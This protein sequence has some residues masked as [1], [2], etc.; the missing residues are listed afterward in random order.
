ME[1]LAQFPHA[2]LTRRAVNG[3]LLFPDGL[4]ELPSLG[5]CRRLVGP[6]RFF[7]PRQSVPSRS[8]N[9]RNGGRT[10]MRDGRDFIRSG[11]YLCG[12]DVGHDAC[13]IGGVA[14]SDGTPSHEII[15]KTILGL[16]NLEHRGGLCGDTGDG[17]GLICQIPQAFFREAAR[18]CRLAG[19]ADVRPADRLA[20][21]VVFIAET[22]DGRCGQVRALIRQTLS[23]RPFHW[24]GWRPVPTRDDVLPALAR[25]TKPHIEHLLLRIEADPAAAERQLY[26]ARLELR[27]HFRTA[28]LDVSIPTLSSRV[29]GYKGLLTGP[30][31]A[32]FYPDLADP[33]F[34]TGL[35]LFHRRYSTNTFPNWAL[36]QPFRLLCHNGEINTIRTTRNAVRAYA[37]GRVPPPPGRDLLTP[38]VS[39]SASLDE[40]IEHLV[41]AR[42]WSLLRALRLS[43]PPVWDSE[44]DA[45]GSE[46]VDLFMYARRAFGGLAAWDGPA[47]VVATDGRVLVGLVDRMGLRPVRWCAD[48]R[49]WLYV[50]SESGIYGLESTRIVA[51]GQL[52]PGQMIALDTPTGERLG[53]RVILERIVA[54]AREDLGDLAELNRQQISVP[55]AFDYNPRLHETIDGETEAHGWTVE[56]LLQ[57]HGWDFERAVVVKEMARLRKEP[58]SS[59]G[60]DRV[61]TVFSAHHPTLFK[62]LQQTFAEVTNPPID[63]YREGGAMSLTTYLGRSPEVSPLIPYPHSLVKSVGPRDGGGR[64][65]DSGLPCRQLELASPVLS[66]AVLE[67]IRGTELL[68]HT[69]L[70]AVFP[71]AG[72][73]DALRES[74]HRLRADAERAIHD[75]YI[76]LC[77]S[78]KEAFH[79]GLA[80]I[81][82]LLAL[83]AVHNYLCQQG[84][85]ERCSLV[86]QAGD[87]QEGHDIAC[88]VGFGAD[89]VH[90]YLIAGLVRDGLAIKEPESKQAWTLTGR[91]CLENVTAAVEDSLR[92]IMSKMGITAVEGYRG[93]MLF[94]AVGLGPEVMEFLGDCPS[95]IG[96]IGLAEL[97]EDSRWRLAQAEAMT[98]LGRNR[99]YRAFNAKVRMALRKAAVADRDR[100]RPADRT[101]TGED[102]Y[103]QMLAEN[104]TA[105]KPN[106]TTPLGM[107][108]KEYLDFS[109]LVSARTPTVLRDLF[110]VKRA[111]RPAPLAEVQAVPDLVRQHFRGAAMSHGALT[112]DSHET[113]TPRSTTWGATRTVA[114]A[115]RPAAATTCLRPPGGRSGRPSCP[116][117]RPI[118]NCASTAT[119]GGVGCGAA[120]AKW[121]AGGSVST[122]NTWSMPTSC[123]SRW[124]RGPSPVKAASS[125]ARR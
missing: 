94:E 20:V 108:S 109:D 68:G 96:G 89:A 119:R 62:Y 106:D 98:V 100:D 115:G 103:A 30:Q 45:W 122:P 18:K 117:E 59:M 69:L 124:L 70:S 82:S 79:D 116:T 77:V 123:R 24:L 29:I 43:V 91:E 90:P 53:D 38:G 23:Q 3:R 78:H 39:D 61:L 76:V 71:L 28:G 14:A 8:V 107:P 58:L 105:V 99:D 110:A 5:A 46:A 104:L 92:K 121:P 86:V 33:A 48:D 83:A 111:T 67:E 112:R 41:H 84:L 120:S 25:R 73:A 17:A 4:I 65:N 21:G 85:R 47:G 97:V 64:A 37:R 125:W 102:A 113:L 34:E 35:A 11:N 88:L 75:G 13:G 114:R 66:D 101:E 54:E 12:D 31:F 32:D 42:G 36:A 80:P 27:H 44:A 72:G 9:R 118:R 6:A 95:R 60:H 50:G 93:A 40:W 7:P 2:N 56:H 10:R 51:S 63:P 52:Q 22:D 74:L 87:V 49:G 19:A 57:A 15:R 26:Q 16:Q 1:T 55:E 81:P